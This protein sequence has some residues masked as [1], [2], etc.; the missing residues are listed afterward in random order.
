MADNTGI[1]EP[2]AM[3][4]G[5][6]NQTSF[7]ARQALRAGLFK[8]AAAREEGKTDISPDH[9]MEDGEG[10][11]Q[12]EV[13]D[14]QPDRVESDS[15]TEQTEPPAGDTSASAPEGDTA[16]AESQAK[17]QADP[18]QWLGY[19]G[20][21][22]L[23]Q[24]HRNAQTLIN[25][26][27]QKLGEVT[28]ERDQLRLQLEQQR[29]KTSYES[30]PAEERAKLEAEAEENEWPSG[31]ALWA[32]RREIAQAKAEMEAHRLET[33]EKD[34]A[35]QAEQQQAARLQAADDWVSWVESQPDYKQFE[36][37]LLASMEEHPAFFRAL[38]QMEP[39]EIQSFGQHYIDLVRRANPERE[40]ELREEGRQEAKQT[41]VLKRQSSGAES[42]RPKSAPGI[43]D[44]AASGTSKNESAADRM[45]RRRQEQEHS[46]S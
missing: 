4:S 29:L 40:K 36:P 17:D 1:T 9:V 13:A 21:E 28:K 26:Q 33:Q 27:G 15:R 34:A 7:E 8:G 16:A 3:P 22:Q 38:V 23:K 39:A 42:V 11:D 45:L 2:I 41:K 20:P 6:A 14:D 46:W 12:P 30:L 43:A 32:H 35:Q 5:D 10:F 19:K 24:A 37:H 44:G 18:E 31:K 25:R